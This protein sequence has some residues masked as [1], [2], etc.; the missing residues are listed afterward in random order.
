MHDK[1]HPCASKNLMASRL[2]Y[3]FS[4][5]WDTE[6]ILLKTNKELKRVYLLELKIIQICWR[7]TNTNTK[8]NGL[9]YCLLIKCTD[10]K[11]YSFPNFV[12]FC[13]YTLYMAYREI[14]TMTNDCW[15][16]YSV[17]FIHV[18]ID[19]YTDLVGKRETL[20]S[21][22]GAVKQSNVLM[23]CSFIVID[24]KHFIKY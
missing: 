5:F 19:C 8:V 24:R 6:N 12:Q 13:S 15:N 9:A 3:L 23:D 11:Q 14:S 16:P 18:L 20:V 1:Q 10:T 17:I 22:E 21:Y 2:S 7:Q 4:Y